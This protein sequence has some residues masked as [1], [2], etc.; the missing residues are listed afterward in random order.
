MTLCI[1]DNS[2]VAMTGCQPTM[3]PSEKLRAL[4]LGCGVDP[5]HVLE[6]E[7]KKQLLEE[8]AARLKAEMEY[9]GPSVLIF[10][11]ECLEAARKRRKQET[12]GAS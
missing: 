12:G 4:I 8:N 11:R 3:V 10:R 1:L 5:A 7:A 2:I 9:R 6:L